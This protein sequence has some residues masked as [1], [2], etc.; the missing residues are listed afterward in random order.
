MF[1]ELGRP[2]KYQS[3]TERQ[4]ESGIMDGM[5]GERELDRE[6]GVQRWEADEG[7]SLNMLD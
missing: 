1:L 4:L 5:R 6:S 3:H 7:W 2:V